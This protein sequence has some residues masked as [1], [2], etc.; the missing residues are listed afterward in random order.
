MPWPLVSMG[1]PVGCFNGAALFRARKLEAQ[2]AIGNGYASLQRGRTL[3]SAEIS[4][5]QPT[6]SQI[7]LLQRG[8]TL[9]S[10]EIGRTNTIPSR[11]FPASTGPHSFERGNRHRFARTLRRILAS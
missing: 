9:S 4:L 5:T 8:R 10:A 7:W 2:Q 11:A 3:S 1:E 6:P